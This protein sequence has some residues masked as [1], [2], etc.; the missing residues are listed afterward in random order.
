MRLEPLEVYILDCFRERRSVRLAI[1]DIV[2]N[3]TAIRYSVLDKALH[4]LEFEHGMLQRGAR[5]DIFEL[6][7]LGKKFTGMV[8]R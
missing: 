6:T 4:E 8:S 2:G 1:A 7:D 5:K 3:T